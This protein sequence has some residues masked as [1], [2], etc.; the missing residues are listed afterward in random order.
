MELNVSKI[1]LAEV[2]CTSHLQ[3]PATVLQHFF[4]LVQKIFALSVFPS[5][6]EH[7]GDILSLSASLLPPFFLPSS[8]SSMEL[9]KFCADT[10]LLD[11]GKMNRG[12]QVNI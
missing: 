7:L 11:N 6:S 9:P 3:E 2:F 5:N 8:S 10:D 4:G 12:I 1:V